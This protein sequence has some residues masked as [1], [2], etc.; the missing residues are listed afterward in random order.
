MFV[1]DFFILKLLF[2]GFFINSFENIFKS[3]IILFKNCIFCSH[4]KWILSLKCKFETT[5]SKV[6]NTFI[7]II[8]SHTNTSFTFIFEHF[9]SLLITL[10][11]SKNDFECSWLIDYKICS[12]VLISKSVS[13]NN[14]WFFPSR[15]KSRNIANDDWFSKYCSI[16]NVS[17]SP[18]RTFPHLFKIKL[19]DSC[20][21]RSN[22]SAFNTNFVLF[23]SISSIN[24]DLIVS[25]ISVF[26]T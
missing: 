14:D 23:D 12:F 24:S 25:R 18:I 4:I 17:N 9:G 20:F 3:S 5:V 19:F 15:N 7:N 22:G 21:I 26:N 11:I 8:H 2:V 10:S 6:F 1:P 16:K 13:S